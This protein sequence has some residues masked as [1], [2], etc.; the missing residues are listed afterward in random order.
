MYKISSSQISLFL[1]LSGWV[2]CLFRYF[3]HSLISDYFIVILLELEGC[4]HLN[5]LRPIL[6]FIGKE[7]EAQRPDF[8]ST[9]LLI[10]LPQKNLRICYAPGTVHG[11]FKDK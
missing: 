4:K 11:E 3:Y 10:S 7:T 8:Y 1:L 6:H 9:S 5:L 2:F